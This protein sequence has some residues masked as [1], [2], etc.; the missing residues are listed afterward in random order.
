MGAKELTDFRPISLIGSVYKIVSKLL[1]QRIKMVMHKLVGPQHLAFIKGRQIIDAILMA[2]E[3]VDARTRSRI[4]GILC[5][6][7][8]Q[9]GLRFKT[10]RPI[11]P[12][13]F[14]YRYGGAISRLHI[15]WNKSFL[16]PVNE[17]PDLSSLARI[18]GGRTGNLPTT[19]LGMPLEAKSKSIGIWNGVI[20]KCEKSLDALR[21][22]FL[23]EGNSETKKFHLVKWDTLIESKHAGGMGIR[24]LKIQNQCLMMKWIWRFASSEQALWKD[25]IQAKYEMEDHWITKMV[26]STYGSC[27][28]RA[29]R[30]HWP[31]LRG[32]C[33][34]KLGNG[35]KTSFWEDRWLEQGSLKT[36]FSDIFTLNQQQRAIVAEMWS[37]QGWNLSFRKPLN[38]QEIQRLVEFSKEYMEDLESVTDVLEN[39]NPLQER[40]R[41][42]IDRTLPGWQAVEDERDLS[43]AWAI[44]RSNVSGRRRNRQW[45]FRLSPARCLGFGRTRKKGRERRRGGGERGGDEGDTGV[46]GLQHK[47]DEIGKEVATIREREQKREREREKP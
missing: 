5:F 4:P 35:R 40:K 15:N 2:N 42:R 38:N 31:K 23:W 32:N 27:L 11:I 19:Y 10:R 30:N 26:C 6:F 43:D 29:I 36:L 12:F 9:R 34:I 24:N 22:N 17:V 39:I 14:Y 45:C 7:S 13:S 21:R 28:R 3:C 25:V 18:L 33:S 20:E 8:S 44:L 16:Y 47:C 1:T 37:N 46:G 41:D